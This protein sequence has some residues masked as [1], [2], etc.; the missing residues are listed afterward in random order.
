MVAIATIP[1]EALCEGLPRYAIP[2]TGQEI[3]ER[4][5]TR[6][7]AGREQVRRHAGDARYLPAL[8]LSLC[9]RYRLRD[10]KG[11]IAEN[12]MQRGDVQREFPLVT[13]SS[14]PQQPQGGDRPAQFGYDRRRIVEAGVRMAA[15]TSSRPTLAIVSSG[16]AWP[17]LV[18]AIAV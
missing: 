6:P 2:A 17:Q 7:R 3:S 14:S 16:S 13:C 18:E 9:P 11:R 8:I 12:R 4:R 15:V 1:L 10:V 5:Q